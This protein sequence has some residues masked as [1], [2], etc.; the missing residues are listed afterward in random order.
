[1]ADE[2]EK[3]VEKQV[4]IQ[5]IYIKDFSFESPQTP[6]V[7]KKNLIEKAYERSSGKKI[8][9]TDDSMLVEL[10]GVKP[11]IVP[12]SYRNIKITTQEDLELAK[13]F[14]GGGYARG[15]RL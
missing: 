8:N 10:L 4:S 11:K 12:G 5:K 2:E 14:L 6:Q 9:I 15:N 3:A 1:M 13:L 7:F